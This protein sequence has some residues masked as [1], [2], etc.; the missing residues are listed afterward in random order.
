MADRAQRKAHAAG[1]RFAV[2]LAGATVRRA[3]LNNWQ[4][5]QRKRVKIGAKVWIRRSNEVIPEIMG[6]VEEYVPG[7]RE[8]QKPEVCPEC[9]CALV[10]RGAHLFCPNREGCKRQIVMRLSHYASRDAMDIDAFSEKTAAQ[11]VD[12][13][14][15]REASDLYALEKDALARSS[16]LAKEGGKA[17]ARHRRE[18]RLQP[19]RVHLRHRH[20]ERGRKDRARSGREVWKP[21]RAEKRAARG[22]CADGGR[23]R[24]RGG[25]HR[26]LLRGRGQSKASRGAARGGVKPKAPEAAAQGGPLEGMTVV[27]TG[28]LET[29]SRAEAEEAVR[30]AG[31]KAAG[32]V[33]K[34]TSLVVAGESAGGKLARARELGVRV[35]DEAEF[36]R[37]LGLE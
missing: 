31:G 34:K 24:D 23:G 29:F 28:T 7:E 12:A 30:R 33:S 21:R 22:A 13:G 10:E 25:F 1:A 6:R 17:A 18:P 15:A 32:S 11:L 16:A 20:T 27:V 5:I 26:G 19:R 36:R 35:A 14:L 9:G 8:V 37:M 2:E 3:T 4:D